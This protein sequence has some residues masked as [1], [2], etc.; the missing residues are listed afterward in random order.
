MIALKKQTAMDRNYPDHYLAISKNVFL[1]N[2]L[3]LS[4]QIFSALDIRINDV[5]VIF[6]VNAGYFFLLYF[7][8]FRLTL[9]KIKY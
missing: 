3:R 7:L 2:G 8:Y 4:Q 6:L 5:C 9:K 1:T